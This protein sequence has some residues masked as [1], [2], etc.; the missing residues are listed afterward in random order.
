LLFDTPV[1]A[2]LEG[3]ELEEKDKKLMAQVWPEGT[4]AAAKVRLTFVNFF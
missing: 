1:P 2:V 4:A 3:F